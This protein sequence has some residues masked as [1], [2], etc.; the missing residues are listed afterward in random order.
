MG[1]ED[2]VGKIETDIEWIKHSMAQSA[3]ILDKVAEDMHRMTEIQI[4]QIEDRRA[5][6]RVFQQQDALDKR[7]SE[8]NASVSTLSNSMVK[9]QNEER[10]KILHQATVTILTVVTTLMSAYIAKKFG[11][12]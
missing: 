10:G 4:Q 8:I 11:F 3:L 7:L 6:E 2:R 12:A 5:I 1:V 9:Q